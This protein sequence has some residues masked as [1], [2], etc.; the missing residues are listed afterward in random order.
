MA[1]I[2]RSSGKQ[3]YLLTLLNKWAAFMLSVSGTGR[4]LTAGKINALVSISLD[5]GSEVNDSR[6]T[7]KPP[8]GRLW[9]SL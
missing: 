4:Y 3:P 8:T 2:H 9:V 1:L 6:G 5:A 7:F